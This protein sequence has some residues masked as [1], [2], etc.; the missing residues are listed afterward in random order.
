MPNV[1]YH[2]MYFYGQLERFN[3]SSRTHVLKDTHDRRI[4]SELEIEKISFLER[5]YGEKLDLLENPPQSLGG[6]QKYIDI[7]K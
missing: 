2:A 7:T 4:P 6:L 3:H 1:L 5:L